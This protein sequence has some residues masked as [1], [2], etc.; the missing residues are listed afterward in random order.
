MEHRDVFVLEQIVQH[1]DDINRAFDKF[2]DN[3]ESFEN[4]IYHQYSCAFLVGQIGEFVNILSDTFKNAHPEIP[5][6]KIVGMR[7]LIDH[8]Y[9]KVDAEKFWNTLKEDIPSFRDFCAKQIGV[10]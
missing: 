9:G 5:W 1:C 8:D 6:F 10:E 2:G 4:N 3:L 7:N